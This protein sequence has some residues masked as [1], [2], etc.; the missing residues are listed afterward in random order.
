M[1]FSMQTYGMQTNKYYIGEHIMGNI[2]ILALISNDI[3]INMSY[4][5]DISLGW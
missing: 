5:D 2:T 4:I 1:K 3:I